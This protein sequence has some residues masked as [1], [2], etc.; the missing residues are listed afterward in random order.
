MVLKYSEIDSPISDEK[1]DPDF[2]LVIPGKPQV[3]NPFWITQVFGLPGICVY[4]NGPCVIEQTRVLEHK[5][6]KW[7]LIV[8]DLVKNYTINPD[9]KFIGNETQ[10][11]KARSVGYSR[12]LWTS[13]DLE[14]L[15]ALKNV[16][17]S[18]DLSGKVVPFEPLERQVFLYSEGKRD[19]NKVFSFY[20]GH[21][22]LFFVNWEGQ[23]DRDVMAHAVYKDEKCGFPSLFRS[24]NWFE[25]MSDRGIGGFIADD[26]LPQKALASLEEIRENAHRFR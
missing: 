6:K 8:R 10:E 7:A 19:S 11:E 22:T 3:R 17:D 18:T 14:Q 23:R 1:I 4:N 20:D 16:D 12:S 2:K 26:N 25:N 24:Q 13:Q 21:M 9:R 5:N 15:D